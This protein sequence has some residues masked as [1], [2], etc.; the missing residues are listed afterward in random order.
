MK[1]SRFCFQVLQRKCDQSLR[2]PTENWTSAALSAIS[3]KG[4]LTWCSVSNSEQQEN[5]ANP[6]GRT[7]TLSCVL[8]PQQLLPLDMEVPFWEP[9]LSPNPLNKHFRSLCCRFQKPPSPALPSITELWNL[10]GILFSKNTSAELTNL[11]LFFS[12]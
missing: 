11:Y 10:S 12:S 8:C 7:Q 6:R 1:S 3:S 4:H 2:P 9:K 5:P